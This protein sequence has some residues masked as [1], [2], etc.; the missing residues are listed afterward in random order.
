[1]RHRLK[2]FRNQRAVIDF[3]QIHLPV[4]CANGFRHIYPQLVAIAEAYSSRWFGYWLCSHLLEHV[5]R[6]EFARLRSA[7]L[8][9]V[10]RAASE[11]CKQCRSL[12]K[13]R[14]RCS[15]PTCL[16]VFS[17]QTEPASR[18][19]EKGSLLIAVLSKCMLCLRV[20]H[21]DVRSKGLNAA[22]SSTLLSTLLL[23]MLLA[24]CMHNHWSDHYQPIT[25]VSMLQV[26]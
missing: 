3:E 16:G 12:V 6:S 17:F 13:L 8:D 4:I 15:F 24:C 10:Q 1:M 14:S 23:P 7:L 21:S 26:A 5:H 11:Q 25:S 18:H 2:H 20:Q 22:S 19:C 9:R